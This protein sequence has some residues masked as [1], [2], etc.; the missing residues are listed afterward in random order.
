L[1]LNQANDLFELND[2]ANCSSAELAELLNGGREEYAGS[3][4]TAQDQRR[5]RS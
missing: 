3:V 5:L 1:I 2:L 4:P